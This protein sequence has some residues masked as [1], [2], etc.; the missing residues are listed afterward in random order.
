MIDSAGTERHA[1]EIQGFSAELQAVCSFFFLSSVLLAL[2]DTS[3]KSHILDSS[4]LFNFWNLNI[5]ETWWSFHRG[6]G[7]YIMRNAT[8]QKKNKTSQSSFYCLNTFV[9]DGLP[10]LERNV[11][12]TKQTWAQFS[13]FAFWRFAECC[14]KVIYFSTRGA[15]ICSQ[16]SSCCFRRHVLLLK[17]HRLPQT[18]WFLFFSLLSVW[19]WRKRSCRCGSQT[20]W[21]KEERVSVSF[22]F[23]FNPQTW[24]YSN[25]EVDVCSWR[26]SNLQLHFL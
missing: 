17:T 13:L 9:L 6:A 7:L 4:F 10:Y 25:A 18:S 2:V 3:T 16:R 26:V 23:T 21:N 5:I 12:L 24:T 14:V 8:Q 19:F 11:P 1:T 20:I 22:C 15:E